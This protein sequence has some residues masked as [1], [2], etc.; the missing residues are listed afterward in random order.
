MALLPGYAPD[1]NPVAY[2][3]AQLK[4]HAPANFCPDT[5]AELEHTA[6]RKPKSGRKRPS[7]I[8]ACW[9]QGELR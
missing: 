9:K 1:G 8:A 6:R 2:L 5:L 4:R 7:I 3:W